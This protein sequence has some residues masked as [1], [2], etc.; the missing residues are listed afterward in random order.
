MTWKSSW[1]MW[2]GCCSPCLLY[3]MDLAVLNLAVPQLSADLRPSGG[4]LLWIIDV[5]GF[6]VAGSLLT[7]G[8]L[9]DRIGRRR[10]PSRRPGRPPTSAG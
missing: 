1:W 4:Q 6:L 10:R 9:G 5:Y 7:M 8:A 2:N 3:A